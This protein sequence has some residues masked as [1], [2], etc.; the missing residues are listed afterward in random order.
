MCVQRGIKS[1]TERPGI[2]PRAPRREPKKIDKNN[3]LLIKNTFSHKQAS[4]QAAKKARRD[5]TLPFLPHTKKKPTAYTNAARLRHHKQARV[6]FSAIQRSDF[7]RD[8]RGHRQHIASN[9]T[10]R[11]TRR[12]AEPQ[13]ERKTPAERFEREKLHQIGRKTWISGLR[14]C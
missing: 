4:K 2:E 1:Q 13:T 9:A 14:C 12:Y 10:T 3:S 11:K 6:C 7:L 8:G 5:D